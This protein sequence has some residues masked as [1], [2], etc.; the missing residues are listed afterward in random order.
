MNFIM[1]LIRPLMRRLGHVPR[2]ELDEAEDANVQHNAGVYE[3][4]VE[5]LKT[6]IERSFRTNGSLAGSIQHSRNVIATQP[7]ISHSNRRNRVRQSVNEALD[8]M[9]RDQQ[10]K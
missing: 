1:Q 5:E 3:R 4:A 10:R 7:H 6:K 2:T 8:Q 9:D